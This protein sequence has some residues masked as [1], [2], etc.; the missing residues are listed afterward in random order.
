MKR[1]TSL[2]LIA[3]VLLSTI[4]VSCAPASVAIK[5]P[6]KIDTGLVSGTVV[7]EK[8]DIHVYQGIPFAAPPVGDLRWKPPQPAASW[9]GVKECTKFGPAP[10]GYFSASFKAYS[11]PS[12]DCLYLNVW[13]P[14]KMTS[15]RLPVMVWI[16][17]GA[18]R[19]GEGSNPQYNGENLNRRDVVVVTF[20]YRLGPFGFLAHPLLSKESEHNSSG[21]YGLLD[22]IAA[23]QWIQKNIAAFGG[24]PNR[25]TIFGQ[26]AGA[27]SVLWLMASPLTKG[28]FQRAISQS[29]YEGTAFAHLQE[30][31]YGNEPKEKMGEQ[32]AKDLGC[33]TSPDPI[34]CMRAKSAEEVLKTGTP[35]TNVL[36]SGYRYEPCVDGWVETD[37]P[38]N[39][40][41]AGKQQDVPLLIGSTADEWALF[42]LLAKPSAD[43]YQKYVQNTFG[44]KAQQVLTMYPAGDDK[45]ATASDKQVITLMTFTCPAK[46]YA[47]A[48]SNVKSKTY[49]YQFTRVPPGAK[50]LGAFHLL[51]IGYVFGKF[52]PFLSPLKAD[53][54]YNDTDKALSDA[55][56]SY[57]TGFAANGDP[58][59]EGLTQWPAYDAQTGQ[60]LNLGDKIE[61]KSGLYNETCDLF[62]STIK[63]KRGQ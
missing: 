18:F 39:I 46:A 10:I 22:Q 24:D 31:K 32:L 11:E 30:N 41:E 12:E 28:L 27:T 3:L 52:M 56:M 4:A 44:D 35:P 9:Q 40:F 16:Y 45:Q 20:N 63:A 2:L 17:G 14:A 23:L 19:F 38:L 29:A 8:Q 61:V 49:F 26:S 43:S 53:A 57:W 60:Y 5:D 1:F 50:M 15:D 51:D 36:A 58:N 54:Y 34:A 47:S 33:D 7:G 13:T 37:L 55:M 25:V 6:I 42:Q 21:N 59:Q 48:M 62:M